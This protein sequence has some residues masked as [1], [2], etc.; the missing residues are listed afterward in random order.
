MRLKICIKAQIVNDYLS[1]SDPVGDVNLK[2]LSQARSID[3]TLL[4]DSF[5]TTQGYHR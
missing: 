4:T 3:R 2:T 5:A 1:A